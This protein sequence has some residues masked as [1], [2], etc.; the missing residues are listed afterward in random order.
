MEWFLL[1]RETV[2]KYVDKS[3]QYSVKEK[4]KLVT[5]THLCFI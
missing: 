4:Q 3:Q 1:S 5:D 2:I